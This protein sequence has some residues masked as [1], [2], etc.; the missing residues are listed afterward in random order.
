MLIDNLIEILSSRMLVQY[1]LCGGLMQ[2]ERALHGHACTNATTEAFLV[3][4]CPKSDSFFR[5][6]L[7]TVRDE[8]EET[9]RFSCS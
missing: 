3:S 2:R 5:N 9:C 7:A 8:S 4:F 6:W 1:K